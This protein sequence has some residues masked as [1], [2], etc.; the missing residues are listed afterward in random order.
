[1]RAFSGCQAAGFFGTEGCRSGKDF[2][3]SPLIACSKAAFTLL[4]VMAAMAVMA[5]ALAAALSLQSQAVD[6]ASEARFTTNA[7]LLA[8]KKMSEMEA[9]GQVNSDSGD[10][11]EDFP[12]YR[13]TVTVA[14]AAAGLPFEGSYHLKRVDL[15]VSWGDGTMG[16]D[17]R[18]YLFSAGKR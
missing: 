10:F 17:L 1:L 9:M 15:H 12:G 14:D 11:G 2:E 6:I 4:E 7:A 18:A 13:W 5:A 8:Q 16:Y 3:R